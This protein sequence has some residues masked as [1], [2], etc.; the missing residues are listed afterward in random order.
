MIL[1]VNKQTKTMTIYANLQGD[2]KYYQKI[3]VPDI[4]TFDKSSS[5]INDTNN[6]S[7]LTI[8]KDDHNTNVE[9][10]HKLS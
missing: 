5:I 7:L 2:S 1:S 3:G 4:E 10:S 6:L 8:R 9:L